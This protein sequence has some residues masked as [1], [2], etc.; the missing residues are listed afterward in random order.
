[1]YSVRD[2]RVGLSWHDAPNAETE[3][4]RPIVVPVNDVDPR[5]VQM[6]Q[7]MPPR[8]SAPAGLAAGL[9]KYLCAGE[10]DFDIDLSRSTMK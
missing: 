1:M 3:R 6:S 8:L 2:G 10:G 9:I 4:S 5:R 7:L